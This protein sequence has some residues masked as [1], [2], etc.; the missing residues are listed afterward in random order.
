[1]FTIR[2]QLGEKYS[3]FESRKF[4]HE[5]KLLVFIGVPGLL[6]AAVMAFAIGMA[7]SGNYYDLSTLFTS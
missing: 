4:R 1:M 6:A 7:F 5:I 2:K 3:D